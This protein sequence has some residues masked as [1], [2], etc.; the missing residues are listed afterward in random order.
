MAAIYIDILVNLP[1]LI[2]SVYLFM[3]DFERADT[4]LLVKN[5]LNTTIQRAQ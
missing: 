4:F 3:F 5:F 2:Y 1:Y